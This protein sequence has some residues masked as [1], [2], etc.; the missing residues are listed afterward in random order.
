MKRA[1]IN[2]RYR[3][4]AIYCVTKGR[5]NDGRNHIT[6]DELE[7][8]FGIG[9]ESLT[10]ELKT[11]GILHGSVGYMYLTKQW[12]VMSAQEQIEEIKKIYPY[13]NRIEEY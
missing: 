13:P 9:W 5:K 11:H 6:W 8:T 10:N 1:D 12:A 2:R 4:C 3:Q 7:K